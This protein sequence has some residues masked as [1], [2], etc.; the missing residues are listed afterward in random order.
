MTILYSVGAGHDEPSVITKLLDL[1]QTPAKPGYKLAE[2]EPLLLSHCEYNPDPFHST[3]ST[4]QKYNSS[5][6]NILSEQLESIMIQ[7][8]QTKCGLSTV[9]DDEREFFEHRRE[10]EGT[11][12]L[13]ALQRGKTIDEKID[14][15]HGNK[16]K[17]FDNFKDWRDRTLNGTVKDRSR[18]RSRSQEK[19][20]DVIMGEVRNHEAGISGSVGE[21]KLDKTKEANSTKG[22]NE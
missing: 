7:Y 5:P 19:G 1:N 13:L 10:R 11:K 17:R 15:L 16:K 20:S 12:S 9:L 22:N 14:C 2:P 6:S 8:Y 3:E 21:D 4:Y 18:S